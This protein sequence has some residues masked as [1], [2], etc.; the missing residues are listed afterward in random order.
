MQIVYVH[1]S[2]TMLLVYRRL[3]SR[4]S[5]CIV[6]SSHSCVV[7]LFKS[8]SNARQK[9]S[10][11][12]GTTMARRAA[13]PQIANVSVVT[14]TGTTNVDAVGIGNCQLLAG[15]DIAARKESEV[16]R[17][18]DGVA[19]NAHAA[20]CGAREFHNKRRR[21]EI[22]STTTVRSVCETTKQQRNYDAQQL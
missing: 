6:A 2:T 18:L 4:L 17:H 22:C 8:K 3:Q 15:G 19:G 21:N 5:T 13:A 16:A 14:N 11:H 1:T 12:R 20:H 9:A 7:R 10:T